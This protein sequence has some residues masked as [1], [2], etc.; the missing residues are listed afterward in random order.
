MIWNYDE[1][2]RTLVM[3]WKADI[4]NPVPKN[5]EMPTQEKYKT[6]R[7]SYTLES[8]SEDTIR[9]LASLATAHLFKKGELVF[10]ENDPSRFFHV[11]RE[12]RVKN[13]KQSGSGKH[14]TASVGGPGDTLN[15]LVLFSG[16]PYFLSAQAMDNVVLLRV[17]RDDYVSSTTQDRGYLLQQL[18]ISEQ[19]VRSCC[20]RLLDAVG[21]RA[22]QR[23]YNMLHMLYA[24]F[25]GELKFTSEEIGELSGTTTET[26]IRIFSGLKSLNVIGSERRN[27]HILDGVEL[28]N[29]C[30]GSSGHS[31]GRI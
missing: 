25:G 5:I 4:I 26:V 22:E 27:I 1:H 28:R 9:Q 31:P 8:A 14:F 20:D 23:V 18:N 16:N 7:A 2:H 21:E 17:K 10:R 24:K 6:L 3:R 11:I 19:V 30:R 13:F 29:L 15:T 12:G